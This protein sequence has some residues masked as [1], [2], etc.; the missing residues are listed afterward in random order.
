MMTLL[1]VLQTGTPAVSPNDL[2][3]GGIVGAVLI[4]F[5]LWE[6][7]TSKKREKT[8]S[9]NGTQHNGEL[10]AIRETMTFRFDTLDMRVE[11]MQRNLGREIGEVKERVGGIEHRERDRLE[12]ALGAPDRRSHA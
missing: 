8:S 2:T 4:G 7:H 10:K 11:D 6:N 12:R 5:K 9:T 1:L 3:T